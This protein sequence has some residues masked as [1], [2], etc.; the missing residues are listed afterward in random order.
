MPMCKC[1]SKTDEALKP[2]N[3]RL[4]RNLLEENP[5]VLIEMHKIET[6]KR[7]PS[8]SLVASYCPF[9]GT[10]Y[11]ARKSRGVLRSTSHSSAQGN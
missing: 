6:R 7:T 11:E 4:T 3:Y 2:M 9:C 1:A 10:K 8:H 5:P